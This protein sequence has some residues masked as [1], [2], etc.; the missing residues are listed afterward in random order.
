MESSTEKGIEV[1]SFENGWRRLNV[2]NIYDNNELR[3]LKNEYVPITNGVIETSL[4][5]SKSKKFR[6][7]NSKLKAQMSQLID[8]ISNVYLLILS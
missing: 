2:I 6:S 8:Q 5:K 1:E 4:I 7:E 3:D